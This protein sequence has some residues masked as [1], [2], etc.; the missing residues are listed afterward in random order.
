MQ[1]LPA[2]NRMF[3]TSA[4]LQSII[5]G[6][7]CVLFGVCI[8]ASF[9]RKRKTHWIIPLSCIYH[10]AIATVHNIISLVYALQGLTN[11]AVISVPDGS[12]LYFA[13]VTALSITML[14]LYLFNILVL[15]LLLIWR[16]YMVWDRNLI[17]PIIM[18][19]L[20]AGHFSTAITAWAIVIRFS[21]ITPKSVTVLKACFTFNLVITICITFGIAYR[22]WRAGKDTFGMT[23]YNAYKP[24]IHTII[25][26]GGIYT[27][28]IVVVYA[29]VFSKS[30]A[31]VMAEIVGIQFATLTPL[32][33]IANLSLGATHGQRNETPDIAEPTFAHPVQANISEEIHIHPD[34]AMDPLP[35]RSNQ[36]FPI[37]GDTVKKDIS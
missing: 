36:S 6:V 33:L 5:Y 17:L 31:A 19:I 28:S 34:D 2:L 22:L 25:Q 3:I 35:T 20:E 15:D 12:T 4:W 16:L 30:S 29:L 14:G 37:Y 11:P 1:K 32:L 13:R 8:Y 21:D 10:F 26:C 24:A 7:N 27:A 9:F 23:G 18:L